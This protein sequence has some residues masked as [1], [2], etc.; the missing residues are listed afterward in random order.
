MGEQANEL[1][2]IRMALR[3]VSLARPNVVVIENVT[4]PP[5]TTPISAEVARIEKYK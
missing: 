1:A 4:H 5:V 2:R 3:Y